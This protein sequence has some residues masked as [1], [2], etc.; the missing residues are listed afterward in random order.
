MPGPQP[1]LHLPY[2][3]WPGADKRLWERAVNSDDPSG[4]TAGRRLAKATQHEYLFAWR[5]FLGLLAIVEPTALDATP[6]DRLTIERVRVLVHHLA[7]TNTPRSLAVQIGRLY[8][9]ARLMMPE[10]DWTWLR[11][12]KARLHAAAPAVA[13]KGPVITSV[14]LLGLGQQL[15]AAPGQIG[16]ARDLLAHSDLRTTTRHYNRARGIEA[17]RAYAQLLAG[18]RRRQGLTTDP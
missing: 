8:A 12:V 14:E 11:T 7:E 16:I 1:R 10:L 5:R 13:P 9:V 3:R 6:S 2:A 15:M 18:R 4:D 17:S